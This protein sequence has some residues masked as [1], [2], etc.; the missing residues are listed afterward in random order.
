MINK[1]F[2]FLLF[3]W[4]QAVILPI[5]EYKAWLQSKL[6]FEGLFEV[7]FCEIVDWTMN[8]KLIHSHMAILIRHLKHCKVFYAMMAE[9]FIS[10]LHIHTSIYWTTI[11][12]Y[13][14]YFGDIWPQAENTLPL[15]TLCYCS[16][17]K[18][19]MGLTA[20]IIGT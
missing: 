17:K 12:I 2:V 11:G 16:I 20:L 4:N 5:T 8:H 13:T 19:K 6:F 14:F 18:V 10:D 1:F 15:S 9:M 7:A 3:L